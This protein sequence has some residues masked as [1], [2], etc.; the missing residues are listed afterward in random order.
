MMKQVQ[1]EPPW[2]LF[3]TMKS[4]KVP[5][6]SLAFVVLICFGMAT[7]FDFVNWDDPWYVIDNPLAKSW[8]PDNLQKIATQVVTRNYAPLT[9]FSFLIDH[10][11][12]GLW[13]GGYHLTNI[14][15]HV[16][17]TILV[18]LLVT[19]FT[20]NRFIGWAT[21]AA[22]AIHPVQVETVVWISSRKGLLSGAFIL[23]SL[24]YWLRKHRTLEQN[25][26]GFIFF[27]CAL[28]SKALA[29]VVPVI[30]FCYDFL[31]A[32]VPFREAVKRQIFPGCCALL[33]LIITMLAQ[34]SELGGVRDHFGMS[35]VELL[36]VDTV[37][38]SKYVQMLLWPETRSVLY[39][40]PVSGIG[41]EII[42]SLFCW[43]VAALMFVRMG[44]HQPL[45][46]FAGVTFLLLLLPV[47]NLFPI[48]TLMNDRYLYL[49][50]IP[51]F[52]LVFSAIMNLLEKI[53]QQVIVPLRNGKPI[54]GYL[55]PAV[56]GG[57]V[58]PLL[59]RYNLQTEQYLSV[60]KDGLSLWQYTAQ[61][62]PQIPVVQ[63]QLAN[64]YHNQGQH[65]EAI[66][67]IKRAIKSTT[68]DELDRQRMEQK[69]QEWEQLR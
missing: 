18:F 47:L 42:I 59:T 69:I 12:Y 54:S 26:C 56:F 63:I 20:R 4:Q 41:W 17:N 21:A 52:A 24:W 38:M 31:V 34:T 35:K 37:I 64:S 50:C 2:Q 65:A 53:R 43:L 49:P 7:S 48:T 39:D 22:F 5:V 3:Q 45:I 60:W 62:V 28:L 23:A 13:A 36:G 8:H 29:V 30:V 46:P 9:I 58:L 44:K 27:I 1:Q 67:I 14:L 25:T 61:Q 68:P 66:E 15:L 11:L 6:F 10:S 57:L 32:K 51:F 55:V 16:I 40:P 19:R 33:L